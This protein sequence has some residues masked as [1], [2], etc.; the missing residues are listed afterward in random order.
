M[1]SII[2][3]SNT[4]EE[5]KEREK[6][7]SEEVNKVLAHYDCSIKVIFVI[8]ENGNKLSFHKNIIANG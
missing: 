2:D 1:D 5:R 3:K 7:C 6:K 4:F 8:E